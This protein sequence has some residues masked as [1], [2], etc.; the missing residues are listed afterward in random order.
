MQMRG[1]QT[2]TFHVHYLDADGNATITDGFLTSLEATTYAELFIGEMHQWAVCKTFIANRM[3]VTAEQRAQVAQQIADDED[4]SQ[5]AKCGL[6]QPI[7]G[8]VL[9]RTT[10]I[11]DNGGSNEAKANVVLARIK[12]QRADANA[13]FSDCHG[14]GCGDC[15]DCKY[16]QALRDERKERDAEA[17]R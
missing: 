8:C 12:A 11:N 3:E 9:S 15:A 2:M 17:N 5:C 14:T 10:T 7:C 16:L 4:D 1:E 13:Y 6:T